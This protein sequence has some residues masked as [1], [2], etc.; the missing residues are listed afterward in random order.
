[1]VQID[2]HHCHL[3]ISKVTTHLKCSLCNSKF[4]PKC[5]GHSKKD[6]LLTLKINPHWVC[7]PCITA[8]LPI[9]C[10]S[11][12]PRDITKPPKF[13]SKCSSCLG[14]SYTPS[15]VKI[16]A[17]CD[18]P[19]HNKCLK[20]DLGCVKCCSS[21]IPGYMVTTY[22][23]NES[24]NSSVTSVF[25][26]YDRNLAANQIGESIDDGNSADVEFLNSIAE[27]LA[28]CKYQQPKN[29]NSP[30]SHELKVFSL[31]V[32]SLI[33][34]VS[35]FREEIEIF[36]KY[37]VLCFNETNLT[38]SKLPNGINDILIDGFHEPLVQDPTR[39]SGK[40]GG[41]AIYVNKRVCAPEKLEITKL[42]L[43]PT[44]TSGEFQLLKIHNC[45]NFN[46]TKVIVNFYRSPS[47]NAQKFLKLIETVLRGL[48]RH[49]RKHI[50]FFGDANID[51]IKY[52]TD[53]YSQDLISTLEKY[54]FVQTVSKPTRVTDHSATLIHR[55]YIN[56]IRNVISCK[57]NII[58]LVSLTTWLSVQI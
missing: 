5:Q 50:S 16:C 53:T 40:G 29:I 13:K 48:D 22:D 42:N 12:S 49:S 45:K 51:L 58:T 54:G 35:Y 55:V 20:G 21:L 33:K 46:K 1:M 7:R 38:I 37:D 23:L 14:W 44:E 32:R 19:V 41:L 4:H 39:K 31:N 34:N 18:S 8:I 26:P 27:V 9:N 3:R 10:C 6:A 17:W 24:Y 11:P 47:N 36:S 56:N 43:D 30:S 15:N 25:N 52:N 57:C 28:S 2:C